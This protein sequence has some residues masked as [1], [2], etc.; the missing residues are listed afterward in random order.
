[1]KKNEDFHSTCE[2]CGRLM[3]NQHFACTRKIVNGYKKTIEHL[4]REVGKLRKIQAV[5][6]E[7]AEDEGLWHEASYASEAYIQKE[8]RRLH[9]IIEE[10]TI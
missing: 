8:L 6:D 10:D 3:P 1:M 7:Q 9:A 4:D 5:V 2:Y